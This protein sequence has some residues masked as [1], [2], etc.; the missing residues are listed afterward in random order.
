MVKCVETMWYLVAGD[1]TTT[2]TGDGIRR[3]EKVSPEDVLVE[4]KALKSSI[5]SKLIKQVLETR[6]AA[7]SKDKKDQNTLRCYI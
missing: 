2:H 4:R 6:L 5:A 1:I 7:M 3:T